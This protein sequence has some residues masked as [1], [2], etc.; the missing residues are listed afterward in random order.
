MCVLVAVIG[1]LDYATGY[2]IA[3]SF[4][5]IVP[6]SIAAWYLSRKSGILV[7]VVCAAVWLAADVM[8]G[9][10]YSRA[11]IPLWNAATRFGFFV[12]TTVLLS[13]VRDLLEHLSR[14]AQRDPLTDLLNGGAFLESCDVLLKLAAR[15]GQ[16]MSLGY[17]DLDGFKAVN[18][19]LGHGVGDQCY[20]R[21]P[22]RLP[23]GLAP[24][25]R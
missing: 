18:D 19:T 7:S 20:G 1:A 14:R 25:M 13:D 12:V 8:S 21:W 9:H 10:S 4:F 2:E 23:P 11:F 5:Y 17:I 24:R 3:F 6:V 22:A 16:P 15:Q